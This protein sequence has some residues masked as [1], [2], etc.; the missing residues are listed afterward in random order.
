M[1]AALTPD[2]AL[3]YL[4]ELSAD[5]RAAVLLD[6]RGE[7]LAGPSALR[8][9]GARA[10]APHAPAELEARTHAG[11]VFAA[12]DGDRQLVVVTGPFALPG[13]TRHDL[14][15]VL[16]R[17][18][19]AREIR[20]GREV[21]PIDRATGAP[22]SALLDGRSRSLVEDR[23]RRHRAV[24]VHESSPP[25]PRKMRYFLRADPQTASGAAVS[26]GPSTHPLRDSQ[27]D[28]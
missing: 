5:I 12:R 27:E 11:A 13:L 16:R 15:T 26:F 28:A 24:C 8:R 25:N 9:P 18:W 7:R 19:A 3:A 14:R 1:P 20:V 22:S 6:A 17:R 4:R 21:A 2:L 23:F 10:A